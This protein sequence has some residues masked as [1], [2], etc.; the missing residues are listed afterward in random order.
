MLPPGA[1]HL[2]FG[3]P[4]SPIRVR[5]AAVAANTRAVDC[6]N[7]LTSLRAQERFSGGRNNEALSSCIPREGINSASSSPKGGCAKD[8]IFL[9][10]KIMHV[11][12]RLEPNKV[13]HVRLLT[14][15]L[16]GHMTLPA[17]E[18]E[19]QEHLHLIKVTVSLLMEDWFVSI[20]T[21]ERVWSA[22]FLDVRI[23]IRNRFSKCQDCK[24]L[25]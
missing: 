9:N 24:R 7:I 15:H 6:H 18:Q 16:T 22:H 13:K 20:S 5:R 1:T 11:L 4:E 21:L 17:T 8:Q 3:T 2:W 25:K 19:L 14:E 12:D 23:P 10:P